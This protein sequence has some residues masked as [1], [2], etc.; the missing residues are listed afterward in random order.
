MEIAKKT[1]KKTKQKI[2]VGAASVMTG[3]LAEAPTLKISFIYGDKEVN[4]VGKIIQRTRKKN[5]LIKVLSTYSTETR[6]D[7]SGTF[8]DSFRK[9][10]QRLL[11]K[12][13]KAFY[14]TESKKWKCN[15]YQW[16]LV[17]EPNV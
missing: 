17:E 9:A 16:S 12:K 1:V 5:N 8:G 13:C 2:T 7:F 6:K 4:V 10:L 15:I 11:E 3:H 14:T